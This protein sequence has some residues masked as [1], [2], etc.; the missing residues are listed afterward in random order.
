[1]VCADLAGTLVE[2]DALMPAAHR[3]VLAAV[4]ERAAG[5]CLVTGQPRNDPQVAQV[6]DIASAGA[7][8]CA[9]YTTRGGCRWIAGTEGFVADEAYLA[10]TR[11]DSAEIACILDAVEAVRRHRP[12]ALLTKPVV[13]DASAVR[14]NTAPET[15][16]SWLDRIAVQLATAFQ[17]VAEG[18]T[19]IF[20]MRQGVDKRRA[21]CDAAS[22]KKSA[23]K[24][25]YFGDELEHGNDAAVLTCPG[26]EAWAIGVAPT[27]PRV[28]YAGR[29]PAAMFRLLDRALLTP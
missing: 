19:S 9:A 26:V 5:F 12:D 18:R 17:V 21:V 2:R 3:R 28:R 23:G 7:G 8:K 29:D 1:M 25:L 20:I 10:G 24:L 13:L 6:L 14:I 15:R 22:R 16:R 4:I 27:D 11:L